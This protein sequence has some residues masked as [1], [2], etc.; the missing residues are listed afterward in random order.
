MNDAPRPATAARGRGRR[1]SPGTARATRRA[2]R[3]PLPSS[4]SGLLA[5]DEPAEQ[6][7]SIGL[8]DAGSP[9]G[10]REPEA[11]RRL[12][13]PTSTAIGERFPYLTAL[14]SRAQRTWSSWSTSAIAS[15]P[16][17]VSSTV[18][19]DVGRGEGLPRPLDPR[20][21]RDDLASRVERARL[22]AGHGQELADHPDRRS[23]CSAMMS[24]R[25][26]GRSV[27]SWWA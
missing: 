26:S 2:K 17:D 11:L 10:D 1:P 24:S 8:G 23:D 3:S 22:E 25:R 13:E 27:W 4:P 14:S 5:A 21:Q 15:Q 9:V 20:R 7:R 6:P 16:C 12:V 18:S 19:V